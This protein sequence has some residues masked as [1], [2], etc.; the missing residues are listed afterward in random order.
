MPG[1]VPG[2]HAVV[3]F[4]LEE[5]ERLCAFLQSPGS[6]TAWVPATSAGMAQLVC[7]GT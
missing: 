4:T 1:L 2:T 3:R 7:F 5:W 6:F